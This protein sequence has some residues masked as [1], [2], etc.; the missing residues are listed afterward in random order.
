MG[1][2]YRA[3]LEKVFAISDYYIIPAMGEGK[4]KVKK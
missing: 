4:E 1:E 3:V 2:E